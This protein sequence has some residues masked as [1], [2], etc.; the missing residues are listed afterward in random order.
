MARLPGSVDATQEQT[1]VDSFALLELRTDGFRNYSEKEFAVTTE[2]M[3]LDKAQLLGLTP[4][5]M[6]VLV[7][8]LRAMNISV[9]GEGVWNK[10]GILD[11]THLRFFT[12][13]SMVRLFNECGL[14]IEKIE[15]I[16]P[17]KTFR[18][19]IPNILTFGIHNDMKFLQYAMR[20]SF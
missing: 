9:A 15:G 19:H 10:E 16:N 3:M 8:G 1:D 20:A 2:E 14:E 12:K 13:K 4:T 6:T 5:E 7:G 18:F 11:N 17:T